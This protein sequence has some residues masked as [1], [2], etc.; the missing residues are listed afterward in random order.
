MIWGDILFLIDFSMDYLCLFFTAK[1]FR[2]PVKLIKLSIAAAVC[3]GMGVWSAM[4]PLQKGIWLFTVLMSGLCCYII[5]PGQSFRLIDI[6][7]MICV[8]LLAEAAAGGFLMSVYQ[9]LNRHFRSSDISITSTSR[10]SLFGAL[11]VGLAI[12]FSCIYRI[13]DKNL[14]KGQSSA[15]K[16]CKLTIVWDHDKIQLPCFFDSG[17][18]AKEPISGLPIIILPLKI[19]EYLHISEQA[20]SNGKI[21]RSRII[22]IKTITANTLLWGIHPKHLYLHTD[23][24]KCKE[25][26]AYLVFTQVAP[27]HVDGP[28]DIQAAILPPENA[29]L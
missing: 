23:N 8:F 4:F 27:V 18:F 21:P 9:L 15:A 14:R 3:A 29:L 2:I 26:D 17:N 11:I 16:D 19:A 24:G 7:K 10:V 1:V 25:I 20:L 28:A 13:F 5:I 22:P 6:L 12:F